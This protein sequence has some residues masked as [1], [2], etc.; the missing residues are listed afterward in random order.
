MKKPPPPRKLTN[1]RRMITI[2]DL[3]AD[4][5][6]LLMRSPR[7]TMMRPKRTARA[8]NPIRIPE[9]PGTMLST[10]ERS[11]IASAIATT[12]SNTMRIPPIT[13]SQ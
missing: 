7:K 5:G 3:R 2:P 4:A 1:E 12:P 8:P 6:L 13:D 10:K 9:A 11:A